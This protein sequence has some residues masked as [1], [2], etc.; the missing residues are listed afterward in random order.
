MHMHMFCRSKRGLFNQAN[1][2][3]NTYRWVM[4]EI[5]FAVNG[6]IPGDDNRIG[7]FVAAFVAV[8]MAL[9]QLRYSE[10]DL[11]ELQSKLSKLHRYVYICI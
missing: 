11:S 1:W 7:K 9:R 10:S 4:C 2:N 3:A 5:V 6:L 8:Y